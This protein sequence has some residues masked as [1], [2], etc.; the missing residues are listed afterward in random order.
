M[1]EEIFHFTESLGGGV[2]S[3]IELLCATQISSGY[4]VSL[5]YL[6]RIDTPE[7]EVLHS[8]MPNVELVEVGNSNL[9]GLL[10]LFWISVRL[11]LSPKRTILHSHSSWAGIAVR[12]AGIATFNSKIFYTPHGYGFLRMDLSSLAKKGAL[13]VE[14]ILNFFSRGV[15]LSCGIYEGR[16]AI[17]TKA[18]RVRVLS[19]YVDEKSLPALGREIK[20]PNP[21]IVLA[22]GR[23][24]EQ[25]N[26]LRF[27]RV[28]SQVRRNASFVWIGDGDIEIRSKLETSKIYV[29]GWL[30]KEEVLKRLSMASMLIIS[31]DWEGLPI[32]AIE[33]LALG[34]PI[35]AYNLK[36]LEE[37]VQNGKTGY[38]CN[39]ESDMTK[40]VEKILSSTNEV[41][42]F[43]EKS[44]KRYYENYDARL[45]K[46]NWQ[47]IYGINSNA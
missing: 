2:L 16:L 29:T 33:A 47:D 13:A 8:R 28:T 5:L 9:F 4:S 3:A 45:L 12:L 46:K 19:N 44:K 11:G 14:I 35:V 1:S 22:I 23:I 27:Q 20:K 6:R 40:A 24:C 10:K 15:V 32:V 41:K 31:S 26:P 21:P 30:G 25:K 42:Q 18:K 36:S 38:L 43:S 34:I 39:S 17:S 37:V 7:K